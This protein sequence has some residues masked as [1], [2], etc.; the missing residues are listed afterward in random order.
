LYED[1]SN[2][3][4]VEFTTPTSSAV[5]NTPAA[6]KRSKQNDRKVVNDLIEKLNRKIKSLIQTTLL[7]S[8]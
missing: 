1:F 3:S 4:T 5:T 6:H 2:S 7:G 8:T